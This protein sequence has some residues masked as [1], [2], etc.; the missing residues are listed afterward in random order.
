MVKAGTKMNTLTGIS[1]RGKTYFFTNTFSPN[2]LLLLK[3]LASHYRKSNLF[4]DKN[5]DII[6]NQFIH[7]ADTLL[8]CP[9]KLIKVK[10]V[11]VL[12]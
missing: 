11:I 1:V 8:K 12:K 3:K 7:E 9:L 2:D 6:M 10:E 4:V 5:D